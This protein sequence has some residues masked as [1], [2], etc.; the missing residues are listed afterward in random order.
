VLV[1][2]LVLVVLAL[3]G[4]VAF[5]VATRESSQPASVAAALVRFRALPPSARTLPSALRGHALQ[6]GVYV[7]D[8]RGVEVSHVLGTRRHPYPRR[9][10]IT[11]S[12]TPGGCL[13]TRWDVLA[14]RHDAALVCPPRGAGWRLVDQSEEHEFAGHVDRRTYV[15]TASSADGPPR[16]LPGAAWHSRCAIPGTTT[17]DDGVVVGARTLL[18]DGR[19]TRTLLLREVTRVRGDTV[20]A[21]TSFTWLLPG[22]GVIV[23]R[24]LANASTTQTIVG[25]VRYEE[26]ATLALTTAQPLH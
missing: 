19:R 15:C 3:A 8:T 4:Y 10:T 5:R 25:P 24:T 11:V 17:I 20:G 2:W 9:T 23:R 13:S 16:M 12:V 6:P 21:G 1:A 7:Y 22:S 14:T 18:L 26:R